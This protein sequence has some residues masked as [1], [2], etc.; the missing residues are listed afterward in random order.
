MHTEMEV[1]MRMVLLLETSQPDGTVYRIGLG[2]Y[3]PLELLS[4]IS[5]LSRLF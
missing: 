5:I 1:T 2:C 4:V 3:I